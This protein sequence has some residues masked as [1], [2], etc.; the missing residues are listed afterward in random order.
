MRNAALDE[1]RARGFVAEPRTSLGGAPAPRLLIPIAEHTAER[2]RWEG[3][4]GEARARIVELERQVADLRAELEVRPA[5]KGK[6]Q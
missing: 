6:R 2:A 3:D 5:K 4:L 1:L